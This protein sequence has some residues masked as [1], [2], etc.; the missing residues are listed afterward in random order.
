MG[1][2]RERDREGERKRERVCTLVL[3]D[4]VNNRFVSP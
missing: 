2:G 4:A 3:I 1:R